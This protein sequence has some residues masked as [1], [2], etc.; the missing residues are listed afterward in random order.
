[1]FPRQ[2]SFMEIQILIGVMGTL[3]VIATYFWLIRSKKNKSEAE[4]K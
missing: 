4:A 1:M 2:E 3:C